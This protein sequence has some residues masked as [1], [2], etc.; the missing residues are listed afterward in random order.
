MDRPLFVD[1]PDALDRE[2]WIAHRDQLV[3]LG[4][5]LPDQAEALK[6]ADEMIAGF[7]LTDEERQARLKDS[8]VQ[9]RS[10]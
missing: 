1:E 3:E 9:L 7:D 4:D 2:G 5:Q 6:R 10:N 8:L